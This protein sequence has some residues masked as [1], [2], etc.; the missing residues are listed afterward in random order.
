[1]SIERR[2][3]ISSPNIPDPSSGITFGSVSSLDPLFILN[4]EGWALA[5][6]VPSAPDALRLVL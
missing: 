2:A 1:M 5:H 4:P 6:A 3:S